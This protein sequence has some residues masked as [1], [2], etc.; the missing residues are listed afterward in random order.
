MRKVK[1]GLALGSGAAKGWAHIGVINAL[2][3][4]GIEIDVVA[5]CSVGALVGSAY[6]N[7]RLPLMEKMGQ[8][9][10]LLGCYSPDGCLLA[11]WRTAAR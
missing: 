3:R 9:I 5:G 4:A 2:E 1:I 11:A 10:S 7:N 6:V 8:C